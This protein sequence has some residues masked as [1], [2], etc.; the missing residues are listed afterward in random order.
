MTQGAPAD[1]YR[2]AVEAARANGAS[3]AD[4][5][6]V[7]IAAAPG[8]GLARLVRAVPGLALAVGYDIDAALEGLTDPTDL[9]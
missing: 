9:R 2:P 6:D 1:C 7:L 8:L 5:V 4:I 3:D